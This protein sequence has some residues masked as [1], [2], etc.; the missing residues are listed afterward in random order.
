MCTSS[1]SQGS[2]SDPDRSDSRPVSR[3]RIDHSSQ[4]A[5]D[6][7]TNLTHNNQFYVDETFV[8]PDN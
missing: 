4:R 8:T 1:R 7:D 2:I 3:K 6:D 5:A